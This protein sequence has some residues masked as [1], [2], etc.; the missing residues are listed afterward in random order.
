M[1]ERNDI[2]GVVSVTYKAGTTEKTF[3]I[4]YN[5]FSVVFESEEGKTFKMGAMSF[6][7]DTDVKNGSVTFTTNNTVDAANAYVA[8]TAKLVSDFTAANEKLIN[9]IASGKEY[10]KKQAVSAINALLSDM[11]APAVGEVVA[12]EYETGSVI[13]INYT[14]NNIIVKVSDSQYELIPAQS[15]LIVE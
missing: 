2:G 12:I 4:N 11:T 8:A 5:N 9:A 1:I 6:V 13:Y 14:S 15:Y 3:Y 10:N 7:T